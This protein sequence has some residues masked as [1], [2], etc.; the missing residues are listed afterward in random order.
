MPLGEQGQPATPPEVS[1]KG[2]PLAVAQVENRQGMS[3]REIASRWCLARQAGDEVGEQ[4]RCLAD[5]MNLAG[6]GGT[7]QGCTVAGG[8]DLGGGGALE[9]FGHDQAAFRSRR[10]SQSFDDGRGN[11][12]VAMIR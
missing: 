2:E 11:Q 4:D 12:P 1:S 6:E 7:V 3:P 5:A 8:K 9:G 10:K